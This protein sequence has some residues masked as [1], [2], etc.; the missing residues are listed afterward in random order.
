[1]KEHLRAQLVRLLVSAVK[2]QQSALVV[3]AK[4]GADPRP[5]AGMLVA[6]SVIRG[7]LMN[8]DE[9]REQWADLRERGLVEGAY[10]EPMS[11]ESMQRLAEIVDKRVRET[12]EIIRVVIK[13]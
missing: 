10:L 11:D 7:H 8:D 3:A 2:V 6:L 4:T 12:S 9:K 5:Y 13:P 1:M